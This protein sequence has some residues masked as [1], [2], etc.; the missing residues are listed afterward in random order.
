[1]VF[2]KETAASLE[3]LLEMLI[4]M[5]GKTNQTTDQLKQRVTQLEYLV[6]EEREHDPRKFSF[7]TSPR[8]R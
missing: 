1:M 8:N 6:K 2:S 5:V 3:Q 4:K 7:Y